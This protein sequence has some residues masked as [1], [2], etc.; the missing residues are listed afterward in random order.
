[1]EEKGRNVDLVAIFHIFLWVSNVFN[2]LLKCTHV[3]QCKVWTPMHE[4]K[5]LQVSIYIYEMKTY[6]LSH[7]T[8]FIYILSH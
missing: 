8:L 6:A 5:L 2:I 1:M 4:V 7:A 3:D